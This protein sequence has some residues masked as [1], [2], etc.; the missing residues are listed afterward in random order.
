MPSSRHKHRRERAVAIDAVIEEVTSWP[1]V[2]LAPHQFD[3][4]EFQLAGAEFGVLHRDGR[5]DVPFV[6]RIRDALVNAGRAHSHPSVPN[7]GWTTFAVEDE[8]SV[9]GA[10]FLLELAYLYRALS[11]PGLGVP[12]GWVHDALAA[13]GLDGPLA[14][15][16]DDLTAAAEA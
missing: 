16:F 14:D 3:A 1:G 10:L 15:A 11:N 4:V 2:A 9:S 7:S 8:D 5:L 6:R 13:L 12:D